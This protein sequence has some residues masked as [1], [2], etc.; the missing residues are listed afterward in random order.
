MFSLEKRGLRGDLINVYK[1][2]KGGS[3]E[4]GA[5]LFPVVFSDQTSD[6]GH[7]LKHRRFCLN[8]RKH[9]LLDHQMVEFRILREGNKAKSRTPGRQDN[10]GR[11]VTLACSGTCLGESHGIQSWRGVQKSWLTF[12]YHLLQAQEWFTLMSRKS[13]KSGRRSA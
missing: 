13:S 9:F 10:P 2:Q 1:Y 11:Q 6:N 4:D 8:I 12:E 3:K 7:K 5:S